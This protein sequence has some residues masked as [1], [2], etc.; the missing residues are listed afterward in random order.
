MAPKPKPTKKTPGPD[1]K[2]E[3]GSSKQSHVRRLDDK[4][5]EDYCMVL[6]AMPSKGFAIATQTAFP[7]QIF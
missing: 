5:Y 4:V 3:P 1:K 7:H 6:V 2:A